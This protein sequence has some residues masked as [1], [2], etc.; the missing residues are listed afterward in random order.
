MSYDSN[1]APTATM[2]P[3]IPTVPTAVPA[4]LTT[5]ATTIPTAT[6]SVPAKFVPALTPGGASQDPLD[7]TRSEHVKL[8]FSS[9]KAL[10]TKYNG[11]LEHLRTFLSNVERRVDEFG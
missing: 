3:T 8:Y 7:Y 11:K 1:V 2:A 10:D 6:T 9:T 4:T 5:T